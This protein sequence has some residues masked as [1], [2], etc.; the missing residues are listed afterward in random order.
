MP[1]YKGLLTRIAAQH[2]NIHNYQPD[3][4]LCPTTQQECST[5]NGA[6]MVFFDSN[7]PTNHG[8]VSLHSFFMRFMQ[9]VQ[10]GARG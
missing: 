3:R 4:V 5:H 9:S 10:A 8:V 6:D 1:R 7:H 2:A